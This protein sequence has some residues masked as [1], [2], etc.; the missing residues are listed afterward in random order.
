MMG[1]IGEKSLDPTHSSSTC[2]MRTDTLHTSL[3]ATFLPQG[4][5]GTHMQALEKRLGEA[6][7]E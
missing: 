3:V 2:F 4:R 1:V 6:E 5:T 7:E